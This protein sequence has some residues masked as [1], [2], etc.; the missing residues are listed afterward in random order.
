MH[1]NAVAITD[2][3]EVRPAGGRIDGL[4][5]L[6]VTL[7]ATLLLWTLLAAWAFRGAWLRALPAGAAPSTPAAPAAP[8]AK[9]LLARYLAGVLAVFVGM[10][11]FGHVTEFK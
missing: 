4:G 9:P 1:G 6:L 10:V 11:L 7:L 8:W 5:E 2:K 3:L